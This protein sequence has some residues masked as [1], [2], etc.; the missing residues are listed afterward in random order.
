MF[1]RNSW[2]DIKKLLQKKNK[3]KYL[4]SVRDIAEMK[5]ISVQAIYK[6]C[7]LYKFSVKERK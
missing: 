2:K 6:Q 3:G 1:I 7:D 5:G 4:Y